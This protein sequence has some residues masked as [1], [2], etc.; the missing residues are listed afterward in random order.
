MSVRALGA[1]PPKQKACSMAV[2]LGDLNGNL[3]YRFLCHPTSSTPQ[4]PAHRH[5]ISHSKIPMTSEGGRFGS[6]CHLT[7]PQEGVQ[8]P[9]KLR[10]VAASLSAAISVSPWGPLSV[11]SRLWL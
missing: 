7:Q 4:P 11:T 9:Q 1:A 10:C 8:A 3:P 2:V 5:P 6:L